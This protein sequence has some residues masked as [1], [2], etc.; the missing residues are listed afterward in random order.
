MLH[1]MLDLQL[2]ML[3][4]LSVFHTLPRAQLKL[5]SND[6]NSPSY[7]INIRKCLVEGFFMQTAHLEKSAH[8]LTIKDNQVVSLHP[9]TCLD[10]KPGQWKQRWVREE[11]SRE[12]SVS[13]D[14]LLSA[15]IAVVQSGYSTTSSS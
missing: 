7:Y 11:S 6:F 15:Y 3:F 2:L 4:A 1:W 8:Y 13:D 5:E 12:E 14:V 9:S 10:D